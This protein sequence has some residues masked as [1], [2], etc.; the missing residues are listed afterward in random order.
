[1]KFFTTIGSFIVGLVK[2]CKNILFISFLFVLAVF[3]LAIFFP[4][5]VQTAINIFKNLLK[6]P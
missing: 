5:D 6:I 2:L 4:Q 1:M 3:I